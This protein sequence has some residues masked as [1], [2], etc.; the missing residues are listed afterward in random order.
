VSRRGSSDD[1]RAWLIAAIEEGSLAQQAS[2]VFQGEPLVRFRGQIDG[3]EREV[4]CQ[5]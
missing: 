1:W 5:N 3:A 2:G 4:S